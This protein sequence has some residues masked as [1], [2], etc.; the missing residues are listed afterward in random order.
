MFLI[1]YFFSLPFGTRGKSHQLSEFH[2]T[3][4]EKWDPYSKHS[5]KANLKIELALFFF[6][7]Q[8]AAAAAATTSPL[9]T[10]TFFALKALW[11]LHRCIPTLSLYPLPLGLHAP[12][13]DKPWEKAGHFCAES[14]GNVPWPPRH[15]HSPEDHTEGLCPT[16]APRH[17]VKKE[18]A[19]AQ[20]TS[21]NTHRTG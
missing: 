5:V 4:F 3:I 16:A 13:Q 15:R 9:H 19:T 2:F 11:G 1:K 20:G 17:G 21:V 12:S 10:H 18:H 8:T 14:P 7:F 6:L